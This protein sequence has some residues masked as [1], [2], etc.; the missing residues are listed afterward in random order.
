MLSPASDEELIKNSYRLAE[1][2]IKIMD[3]GHSNLM[4]SRSLARLGEI[5]G[6]CCSKGNSY[7]SFLFL[8]ITKPRKSDK[9]FGVFGQDVLGLLPYY[10]SSTPWSSA[11]G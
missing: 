7:I 3:T 11:P 6:P 10:C 1:D 2:M 9:T 8:Y 4:T 5:G